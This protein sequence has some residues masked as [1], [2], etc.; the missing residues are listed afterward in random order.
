ME[1]EQ[2]GT[3]SSASFCLRWMILI[4]SGKDVSTIPM[5]H[6]LVSLH[7]STENFKLAPATCEIHKDY[8]FLMF[9]Q[10]YVLQKKCC[11]W[12][13]LSFQEGRMKLLR[14]LPSVY[15]HIKLPY[16]QL[17]FIDYDLHHSSIHNI[18]W[19]DM[20]WGRERAV[21]LQRWCRM[22]FL[23]ADSIQDFL[24]ADADSS[25]FLFIH[26]DFKLCSVNSVHKRVEIQKS[27]HVGFEYDVNVVLVDSARSDVGLTDGRRLVHVDHDVSK[28]CAVAAV[29]WVEQVVSHIHGFVI[30]FFVTIRGDDN[31]AWKFNRN[32]SFQNFFHSHL[33]SFAPACKSSSYRPQYASS[34]RYPTQGS[35]L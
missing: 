3:V 9:Q 13:I 26:S 31:I 7:H 2:N 20:R 30:P 25:E 29:Q 32:Q 19:E 18:K 8:E 6:K 27:G 28:E 24:K 15:I 11:C 4:Q 14:T 16:P 22:E 17:L 34:Q 5:E 10:Q 33:T 35:P 21:Y 1:I 12:I 23:A